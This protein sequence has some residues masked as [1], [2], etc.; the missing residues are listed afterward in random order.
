MFLWFAGLSMIIV[1]SVFKSPA[2]DY[3]TV[4]LGAVLPVAELAAGRP[5][6][7]HTLVAAAFTLALVVL[8]TTRGGAARQ[9]WLGLPIGMLLHLVLDGVWGDKELFWW[10][11][12]GLDFADRRLP[13][14]DRGLFDVVLELA[15]AVAL[16]WWY[17]RFGL[18][19]PVRRRRFLRTGQV[20]GAVPGGPGGP[21][22]AKKRR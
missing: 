5:L 20:D 3:R 10:P 17:R 9:R 14:L 12:F 6:V 7:L 8:V 19:D 4:A 18:A 22:R 11:A 16:V 2:V 21:G 15:G 13:E 1:W